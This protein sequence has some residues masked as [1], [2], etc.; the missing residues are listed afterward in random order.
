[1]SEKEKPVRSGKT[2]V[3]VYQ[4][5]EQGMTTCQALEVTEVE[6]YTTE[7]RPDP[8]KST[9]TWTFVGKRVVP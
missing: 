8:S 9:E 3:L 4:Y 2:V 5:D 7:A 6:S 1:M